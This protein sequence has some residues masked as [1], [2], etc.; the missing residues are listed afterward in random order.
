MKKHY[1]LCAENL[2]LLYQKETITTLILKTNIKYIF[3]LDKNF[4]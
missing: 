2:K 3:K 4:E 1:N